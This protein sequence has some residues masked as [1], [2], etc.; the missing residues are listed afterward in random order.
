[1]KK[2]ASIEQNLNKNQ[3]NNKHDKSVQKFNNKNEDQDILGESG[4]EDEIERAQNQNIN[5][6]TSDMERSISL[7]FDYL[8][9]T[10][11]LPPLSN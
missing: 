2:K 3:Q 8:Q 9:K 5:L 4:S 7:N 10:Q 6:L 1:M 11:K